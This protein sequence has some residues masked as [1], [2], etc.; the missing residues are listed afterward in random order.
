MTTAFVGL[1]LGVLAVAFVGIMSAHA[2]KKQA[3]KQSRSRVVVPGVRTVDQPT[4]SPTQEPDRN[5]S[6][7][8]AVNALAG[9]SGQSAQR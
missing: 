8:A 4:K 3:R 7:N 9:T 1:L 2:A 6:P 5:K